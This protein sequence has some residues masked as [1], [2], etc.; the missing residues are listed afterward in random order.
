MDYFG[1]RSKRILLN[2]FVKEEKIR[3]YF[4][5]RYIFFFVF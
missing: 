2:I 1:K 4:E 3:I 5:N